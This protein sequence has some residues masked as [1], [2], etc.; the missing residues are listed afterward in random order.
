[1]SFIADLREAMLPYDTSFD[2]EEEN[3][4]IQKSLHAEIQTS[5]RFF[6]KNTAYIRTQ[7]LATHKIKN[8]LRTQ[9]L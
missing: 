9:R 2:K 6:Y 7:G 3:F 5:T 1:M 4:L 8:K